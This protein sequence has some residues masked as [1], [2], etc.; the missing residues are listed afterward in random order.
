M[1]ADGDRILV[2]VSGGVDSL[3]L[4]DRLFRLRRNARVRFDLFGV[5]IDEGFGIDRSPLL[6]EAARRGWPLEIVETPIAGLLHEKG[7]VRR[8]CALCSRLRRGFL[9][10]RAAELDCAKIALGHHRDDLCVTF[11]MNL[12]R[13]GGLRT[14]GPNVPADAG[15]RRVIRPLCYAPKSLIETVAESLGFPADEKCPHAARLEARGDRAY[16]EKLLEELE[17]RFPGAGNAFLHS[18][19]DLRPD[20][21]LDR[22][23][24]GTSG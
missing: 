16:L 23:F 6:A 9:Y 7:D 3:T 2:A 12:L 21:L 20:H 14:M 22:R 8:P 10:R 19:A 17:S 5:L 11:L 15:R 24:F 18:L 13:G 4:M 1:I